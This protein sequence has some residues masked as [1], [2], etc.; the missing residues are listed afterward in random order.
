MLKRVGRELMSE[1]WLYKP[2]LMPSSSIN[3]RAFSWLEHGSYFGF[4]L[5]FRP[6]LAVQFHELG[7][8]AKSFGPSAAGPEEVSEP[9][10][11][12]L[13]RVSGRRSARERFGD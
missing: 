9:A 12:S 11:V 3:F 2:M 6:V 7:C 13:R 10:R 1:N 4:T 8:N 5:E